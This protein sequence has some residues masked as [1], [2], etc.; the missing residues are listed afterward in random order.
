MVGRDGP[1]ERSLPPPLI[2]YK[3]LFITYF[4][5]INLSFP[6]LIHMASQ[7]PSETKRHG[8]IQSHGSPTPASAE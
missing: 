5:K 4:I 7:S 1:I 2:I 6:T 3:C 8:E